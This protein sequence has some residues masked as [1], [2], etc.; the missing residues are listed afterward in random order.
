M[1]KKALSNL[2]K[3][4]Y[5]ISDFGFTIMANVENYYWIPFLTNIAKFPLA[6]IAIASSLPYTFDAIAQP[7]YAGLISALKPMRWGKNRSYMIVFGPL[8]V[9]S[10][11]L[12]FSNI[13]PPSVALLICA[14][15]MAATNGTRTMTWTSN[16]NLIN[17][18]A[19]NSDERAMLASRRSTWTAASGIIY[20]YA[21]G[22]AIVFLAG[23]M[24]EIVAYGVIAAITSVFYMLM[25][26][27]TVWSTKGY[28][29]TGADAKALAQTSTQK[30]SLMDILR[31][32]FQN[33]YLLVLLGSAII[34]SAFNATVT[35][36]TTYYFMYVAQDIGLMS[37]FLL[38][39]SLAG[40]IGAYFAGPIAKK[41]SAKTGVLIGQFGLA[42]CNLLASFWG[43]NPPVVIAMLTIGRL[44]MF[45][46]N[47][48]MVALYSECVV[49]ARWKTGKDTSAFVIGSQ[50][51]PIKVGLMLR[52]ILIP[53]I[54]AMVSFDPSIAVENAT[55]ALK[56]GIITM[57]LLLPAIGLT[58]CG[59]ILLFGFRLTKAK[60]AELQ[61]E[62]DERELAAKV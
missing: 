37:L 27:V 25:C 49:Y 61:K 15:A 6:A 60:V 28:E 34:S 4:L 24:D 53:V 47:A 57:F 58:L 42:A 16:L 40:V 23:R 14:I 22:P 8:V 54:L 51:I 26:W 5:G 59:L 32:A 12:C 29:A 46:M 18:L 17:V 21:V 62:I 39:T 2:T 19:N 10:F 7:V 44:F 35:S 30:I 50:T 13:G 31:S 55:P 45:F 52:G 3:N 43:M 11:I 20:A 1:A 48:N 9:L 33:P 41:T 56:Q 36:A 38:C